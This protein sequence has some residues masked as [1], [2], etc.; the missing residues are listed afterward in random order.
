MFTIF[1]NRG[2]VTD[3]DS[4]IE[5]DTGM[6]AKFHNAMLREGIYLP[7]SQFEA[8]FVSTEHKPK[9]IERT[10]LAARKIKL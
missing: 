2:E 3:N 5:S 8:C 6:F 4:A 10:I 1:F 7:P 9:D